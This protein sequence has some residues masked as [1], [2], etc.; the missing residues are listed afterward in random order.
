LLFL[1]KLGIEFLIPQKPY[2]DRSTP[3]RIGAQPPRI[4]FIT[5]EP[6]GMA[7]LPIPKHVWKLQQEAIFK[8]S[9]LYEFIVRIYACKINGR[10]Y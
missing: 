5:I 4:P 3:S 2:S 7:A 8:W 10:F 9:I 1:L 6:S